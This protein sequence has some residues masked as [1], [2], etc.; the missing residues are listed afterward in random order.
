MHF[1]VLQLTHI[2]ILIHIS[3][4]LICYQVDEVDASVKP[5]AAEKSDFGFGS[6]GSHSFKKSLYPSRPLAAME[7]GDASAY[8]CDLE[9]P[10]V[11]HVRFVNDN[12]NVF[13]TATR[14]NAAEKSVRGSGNEGSSAAFLYKRMAILVPLTEDA[15][16]LLVEWRQV[17]CTWRFFYFTSCCFARLVRGRTESSLDDFSAAHA[18]RSYPDYL[19]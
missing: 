6:Y 5:P 19:P 12:G 7:H 13:A 16:T 18:K 3:L 9:V 15:G 14:A 4:S 2:L 11:A 17:F 10:E 1:S 8:G